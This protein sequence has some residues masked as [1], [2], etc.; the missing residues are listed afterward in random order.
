MANRVLHPSD[1][2]LLTEA[3][4]SLERAGCQFWHCEGP[5]LEPVDM[6]TCHRCVAVAQLRVRLGQPP[7][8]PEETRTYLRASEHRQWV[9]EACHREITMDE[10]LAWVRQGEAA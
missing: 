2:D 9:R 5:T 4:D 6:S 7:S 8:Y 10:A 3:L 1:A